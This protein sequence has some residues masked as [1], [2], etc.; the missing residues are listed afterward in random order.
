MRAIEQG[1]ETEKEEKPK[2]K[3]QG[4]LFLLDAKQEGLIATKFYP[5]AFHS[6]L[7]V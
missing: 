6:R 4:S 7:K 3:V 5:A 1:R 2:K